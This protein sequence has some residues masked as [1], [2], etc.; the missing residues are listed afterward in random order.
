MLRTAPASSLWIS[1]GGASASSFGAQSSKAGL[2]KR[3]TT[4]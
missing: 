3:R 4:E 2:F 1:S